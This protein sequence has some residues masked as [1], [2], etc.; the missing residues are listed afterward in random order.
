MTVRSLAIP[1]CSLLLYIS[2]GACKP[3]VGVN[4]SSPPVDHRPVGR[5]CSGDLDCAHSGGVSR[6][7]LSCLFA[8]GC[9]GAARGTC[10]EAMGECAVAR[11]FCDC[12]GKTQWACTPTGRYKFTGPC[13]DGGAR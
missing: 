10:G 12:A 8:E 4:A 9:G 3:D 11:P 1:T 13:E 6:M 7:P 5:E 2:L